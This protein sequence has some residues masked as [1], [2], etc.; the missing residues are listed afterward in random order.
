MTRTEL[1]TESDSSPA[2]PLDR[3]PERIA[4]MFDAIAGRYDLLN[5][6]LSAGFDQRWRARAVAALGLT[7]QAL[8]LDL[9][10]GTADLALSTARSAREC[11]VIG[12]DFAGKMLGLAHAK[13]QRAGLDQRVRLVRGDAIYVPLGGG[14]VDAV[15]IAFGIRNV[16][17][18]AD[19]LRDIHRVL[20]P[21]GRLAILE[22]GTPRLPAVRAI[23]LWYF[24][25][26][27]PFIGRCISRHGSAYTYLPVSVGTFWEPAVFCR[28][29][30]DTGFEDVQ[31]IPLTFGVVYLYQATRVASDGVH[32]PGKQV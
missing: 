6:L 14:A 8:V 1:K 18:P 31:A 32:T 13:V 21:G 3:S 25:R 20:R 29:L 19:A 7:G 23:Y 4:G 11:R 9:C 15:T 12:V 28:V 27:L 10:T 2:L 24:R 22:F 30:V 16:S 5:R 26:V 17:K